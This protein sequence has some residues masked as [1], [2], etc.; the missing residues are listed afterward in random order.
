MCA[1]SQ[2]DGRLWHLKLNEG[3][4]VWRNEWYRGGKN[5]SF[6]NYLCVPKYCELPVFVSF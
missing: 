4:L 2:E 6:S 1:L 5:G 3:P